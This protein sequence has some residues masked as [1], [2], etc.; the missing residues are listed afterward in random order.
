MTALP[1]EEAQ[2]HLAE[3]VAQLSP[4]QE[5]VLTQ[6]NKPVATLAA[7]PGQTKPIPRLGTLKG[8]ILHVAA[9]FDAIPTGFEEYLP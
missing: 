4:G 2:A 8:T 1:L 7:M 3:I 6:D 5:T 9:D